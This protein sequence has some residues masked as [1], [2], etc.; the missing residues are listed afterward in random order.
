MDAGYKKIVDFSSANI[1]KIEKP[2]AKP[3]AQ[4]AAPVKVNEGKGLDLENKVNVNFGV[5][6]VP[7]AATSISFNQIE[8]PKNLFSNLAN[9]KIKP[10][11]ELYARAEKIYADILSQVGVV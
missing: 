7:Q 5:S 3:A 9:D 8:T 6:K 4:A 11:G 2:E 10:D 1:G